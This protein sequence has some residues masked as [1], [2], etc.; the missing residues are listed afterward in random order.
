M[1]NAFRHLTGNEDVGRETPRGG[2]YHC[3]EC[4]APPT[5]QTVEDLSTLDFRSPLPQLFTVYCATHAP[6][7]AVS[8]DLKE[9][10]RIAA[11]SVAG[12][13]R[14]AT[15]EEIAAA[16]LPDPACPAGHDAR[17]VAGPCRR[18]YCACRCPACRQDC[19]D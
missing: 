6:G 17:R 13:G 4:G 15:L 7:E 18:D 3:I 14:H 1:S 9:Q 16:A 2:P 10:F 12:V 19:G 8:L 11:A 5:H